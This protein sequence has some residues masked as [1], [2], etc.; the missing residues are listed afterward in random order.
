MLPVVGA[1]V[2]LGVFFPCVLILL[3]AGRA[4]AQ[5]VAAL[6]AGASAYCLMSLNLF[7]ATRPRFVDCLA[8][9]LDRVYRVHKFTGIAILPLILFHKYVGMDLEGQIVATGLAKTSVDVAKIAF[10]LLLVLLLVS[11]IKRLPKGKKDLVPYNIWRQTHRLMG[12]VFLA[13]TFHQ[14]FVKVPF[15]FNALTSTYLV[16]MAFLGLLSFAFTQV[17]APFR[18]RRFKVTSIESHKLATI[19]NAA[20]IRGAFRRNIR[21]GS[22]ALVNFARGGLREPHP[23]TLSQIN[24]DGSLQISVRALGDYTRRLADTLEIGDNM[25][26]DAPYGAFDFRRGESTQVWMAGGIGITPFLAFAAS[27]GPEEVRRIRLIYCVR[28]PDEALGLD[29]L[30]EAEERCPGFSV[31]VHAS[32]QDGRMSASKLTQLIDI[33]IASSGFWF[34]GPAQMRSSIIRDLRANKTPPAS[35]HYEEFEFR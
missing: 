18:R 26:I 35:V 4:N 30:R 23:F 22:F 12:A 6:C 10:P 13:L 19:I 3:E 34:C 15:D 9:G 14:I 33:P 5:S 32:A 17:L 29:Q 20:P 8:G 16:A 27:L 28:D 24:D 21:P 25:L 2:A 11:W 7:L 31:T 1:N